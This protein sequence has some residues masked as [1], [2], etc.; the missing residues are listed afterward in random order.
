MPPKRK[1]APP[2][3]TK[4]NKVSKTDA[5]P[6]PSVRPS[7][8]EKR[9]PVI[10][11]FADAWSNGLAS[12]PD[13][14][15][16]LAFDSFFYEATVDSWVAAIAIAR[17]TA[18][19]IDLSIL[20]TGC[21]VLSSFANLLAGTSPNEGWLAVDMRETVRISIPAPEDN[22]ETVAAKAIKRASA[23]EG[24]IIADRSN[25]YNV[26]LHD[27][28]TRRPNASDDEAY[29]TLNSDPHPIYLALRDRQITVLMSLLERL[30]VIELDVYCNGERE[31]AECPEYWLRNSG[32][33]RETLPNLDRVFMAARSFMLLYRRLRSNLLRDSLSD[34]ITYA[35]FDL[36]DAYGA[37]P[38]RKAIN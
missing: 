19:P 6:I 3:T 16:A 38:L 34:H 2:I 9:A 31:L 30:P 17:S 21:A 27:I 33:M 12:W 37:E 10:S 14:L 36:I 1:A 23:A 22:A 13:V 7:S 20:R 28:I 24:A 32:W 18:A 11:N 29:K 15:R 35:I 25:W 5:L 8:H 26:G 4:A